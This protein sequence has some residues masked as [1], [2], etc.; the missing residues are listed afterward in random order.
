M[1]SH[2]HLK[3]ERVMKRIAILSVLLAASPVYADAG[4]F[5]AFLSGYNE[6]P[7]VNSDAQG[8]FEARAAGDWQS[9]DFVLT[10]DGLQAP[11]TQAHI[12]FAQRRVNGP[13]VI[14]L[15]GTTANPG[16]AG[17]QT[18][19][20]SGTVRGTITATNVLASPSTQQLPAGAIGDMI[21][22]MLAGAAYANVHTSV[23]GGGEIRGQIYS[24]GR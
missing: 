9:I 24:I 1:H 10:Y 20:Q 3:E 5:R 18:C 8:R 7:S 23:S 22:A 4:H 14:W 21:S 19:P 12:H 13:I 15:C 16:P 2:S 17:T 11:V 6:V